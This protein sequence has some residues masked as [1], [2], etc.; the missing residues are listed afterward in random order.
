[1]ISRYI[2]KWSW[3]S[4]L[5]PEARDRARAKDSN[6]DRQE[7]LKELGNK[8]NN[9]TSKASCIIIW[10]RKC[11]KCLPGSMV[12]LYLSNHRVLNFSDIGTFWFSSEKG[13]YSIIPV[14]TSWR[15]WGLN[16]VNHILHLCLHGGRCGRYSGQW[17][18]WL[19]VSHMWCLNPKERYYESF[20]LRGEWNVCRTASCNSSDMPR[21]NDISSWRG[22]W[23][24]YCL[25]MMLLLSFVLVKNFNFSSLRK[26][27]S[28]IHSRFWLMN[29]KQP[30]VRSCK[31]QRQAVKRPMGICSLKAL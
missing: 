17:G 23:S 31:T 3:I 1:M 18:N 26:T 6:Q 20:L 30:R 12:S 8:C 9:S 27:G 21:I 19:V 16:V 7:S 5:S 28:N 15:C 2:A 14:I 22:D 11:Y 4:D 25:S 29:I 24:S 10:A 13:L